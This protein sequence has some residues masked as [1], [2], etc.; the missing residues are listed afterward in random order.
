MS[1]VYY[2]EMDDADDTWT[3]MIGA[4]KDEYHHLTGLITEQFNG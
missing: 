4:G 3:V 2:D 1:V